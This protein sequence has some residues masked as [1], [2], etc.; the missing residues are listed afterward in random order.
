M[1]AIALELARSRNKWFGALL[2]IAYDQN[3][4]SIDDRIAVCSQL[5]LPICIWIR[6][7]SKEALKDDRV[8]DD[9]AEM[10]WNLLCR[11]CGSIRKFQQHRPAVWLKVSAMKNVK[12]SYQLETE[13]FLCREALAGRVSVRLIDSSADCI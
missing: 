13:N 3:A 4:N 5:A 12:K 10:I 8:S 1:P 2:L 6:W 9:I 7:V 11:A